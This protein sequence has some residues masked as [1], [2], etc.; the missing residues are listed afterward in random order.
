MF[1]HFGGARKVASSVLSSFCASSATQR[2]SS[3]V[4][5]RCVP[6]ASTS[7]PSVPSGC[8]KM[9]C[10]NRKKRRQPSCAQMRRAAQRA[11]AL[12]GMKG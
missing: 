11:W 4:K 1:H 8:T 7:T 9:P 5:P 3:A 2:W 10:R 6:V 12:V